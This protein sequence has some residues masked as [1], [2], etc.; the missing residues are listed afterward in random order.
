MI[1]VGCTIGK[2]LDG[3]QVK[4]DTDRRAI[5]QLHEYGYAIFLVTEMSY[6][7]CTEMGMSQEAFEALYQSM[8]LARKQRKYYNALHTI[9]S[10]FVWTTQE[11]LSHE[12]SS[13]GSDVR[14][15]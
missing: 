11:A 14:A 13:G 7:R 15:P 10:Y 6:P 4:I 12:E 8:K 3:N 9:K 2:F 1:L 5:T